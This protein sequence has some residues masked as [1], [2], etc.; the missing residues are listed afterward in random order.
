MSDLE[1][2]I[3]KLLEETSRSFYLTLNKLP[4]GVRRQIGLLYL[5]ARIADTIADSSVG[6]TDELLQTLKSYNSRAQGVSEK[7][8]D[9]TGLSESQACL[10][11][12]SPSPR[13][14]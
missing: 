2:S 14:Q 12:T 7:M 1:P 11:Y 8:P 10:L 9:M 4:S 6:T 5:L 3:E 13:D